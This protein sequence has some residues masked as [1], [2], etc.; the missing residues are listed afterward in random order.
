MKR[1][2][3]LNFTLFAFLAL[4][5]VAPHLAV[6]SETY[7]LPIDVYPKCDGLWST[8][9]ERVKFCHM[10]FYVTLIFACAVIHTFCYRIFLKLAQSVHIQRH[11]KLRESSKDIAKRIFSLL[12][13]VEIVFAL[14]LI[15]LFAVFYWEY[16][17]KG[18]S[19]YIDNLAYNDDKYSE[20]VFV[21]VVMCIAA[22]RPI[23][24]IASKFISLFAKFGGKSIRA[25][26][27]SIICV[28]SLLGSFITEPAAIAICSML[29]SEKFFE[30]RPS[31][32]FKYATLALL[33]VSISIGGALTQ[34]AAPP[35][36][37]VARSWD[38]NI[39]YMLSHFG[40]KSALS[41][42]ISATLFAYL[43]R[44]E[45]SQ[46][47]NGKKIIHK[48]TAPEKKTPY[49][50]ICAHI[51][52]L[53]TSVAI[54]HYLVMELFLL[55]TFIAF[56]DIT[57]RFQDP[58]RYRSPMLVAIF[59]GALVT[60]GT[61]QTW[62]LEP[63]LKSLDA[64]TLFL[65]SVFL[66]SFNDN[67]AITYLASLV[68]GFTA[69]MKYFVVAGAIGGGGL[70]VIANAPNLVAISVLKEDFRTGIS[71]LSLLTWAIIPTAMACFI[72]YFTTFI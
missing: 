28:G 39:G 71:P 1:P 30:Y 56:T 46:M 44:S 4:C 18:L 31:I 21:M 17:W 13:E 54:M 34:F 2:F 8:L 16:G 22:T 67:A 63:V 20:P 23:V 58:M 36:I 72:F 61:L 6:A 7:P 3:Y 47:E 11:F 49:W 55:L 14:W 5:L 29:L 69:E 10:N 45:F 15:P 12:G 19:D 26:W 24:N 25:W 40:W 62:W 37:M 9:V 52:F 50:I 60:H 64:H 38:W 59:L 51:L 66:T 43:F 68:S 33:F 65:G 53:F 35:I 42:F 57:Q 27:F 32:K 70:T 41:I 48:E